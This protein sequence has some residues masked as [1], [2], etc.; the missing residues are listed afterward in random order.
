MELAAPPGSLLLQRAA[1]G[2]GEVVKEGLDSA[3]MYGQ[4][5]VANVMLGV[6]CARRWGGEG[7][8]SVVS[9]LLATGVDGSWPC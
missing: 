4:S 6:E 8:V 1:A 7:I 2:E 3:Q 5:K 9:W